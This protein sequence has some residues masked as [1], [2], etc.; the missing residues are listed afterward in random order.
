MHLFFW[1][2]VKLQFKTTLIV[3]NRLLDQ[4]SPRGAVRT[5]S[6]EIVNIWSRLLK[7]NWWNFFVWENTC[8]IERFLWLYIQRKF[9]SVRL[10]QSYVAQ[11]SAHACIWSAIMTHISSFGTAFSFS[12]STEID[13]I[14]IT[15]RRSLNNMLIIIDFE[16]S[17]DPCEA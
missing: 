15:R 1:F 5:M 11:I 12:R 17:S 16:G 7:H 6:F 10:Y 2:D 13:R 9:I 14:K 4:K 8:S 3:Y